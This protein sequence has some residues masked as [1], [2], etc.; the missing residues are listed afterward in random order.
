MTTSQ[1]HMNS[2]FDT[3]NMTLHFEE[4]GSLKINHSLSVYSL[5]IILRIISV[6]SADDCWNIVTALAL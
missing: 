4:S 5:K 3:P 6:Q 2:Q 1:V